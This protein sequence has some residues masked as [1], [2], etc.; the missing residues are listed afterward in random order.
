MENTRIIPKNLWRVGDIVGYSSQNPQFRA[1][2][3]Q[4]D[5]TTL[6]WRSRYGTG[7]GNGLF[8]VPA[9]AGTEKVTNGGFDSATTGWA[10]ANGTLASIAGGYAGNCLEITAGSGGYQAASQDIGAAVTGKLYRLSVRVKSGTSGNED[11]NLQ[12]DGSILISGTSSADWTEYI[13]YR[14]YAGGD[15]NIA[16]VK[17]TA[18]AGTMLFDSISIQEITSQN[19]ITFDEGST[20]YH[21]ELTAGSYNGTTLATEVKTRLDAL[22]GTYTCAYSETTGKFTIARAA[23]NFTLHWNTATPT[24]AGLL[25]FSTAADDTGA[26]TYT[27][28]YARFNTYEYLDLDNGSALEYDFISL[29]NHNLSSAAVITLYG[30]DDSAFTTNLVSDVIAYNATNISAFLA[31]ARTKR[32]VRV[33]VVD[34]AN[35][36][37]Y[38]S[39]ATIVLGKYRDL[40]CIFIQGYGDGYGNESAMEATP[41]GNRFLTSGGPS[42]KEWDLTWTHLTGTTKAY[43]DEAILECLGSVYALAV[44]FDYTA[45]NDYTHWAYLAEFGQPVN[46]GIGDTG[47]ATWT[48]GAKLREHV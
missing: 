15:V 2:C 29:R 34:P 6:A 41:S 26:A 4:D 22:G 44:C 42:L 33:K 30:A 13:L 28:D 45:P 9:Y 31:A 8:V 36:A 35:A 43:V 39:I 14:I 40:G 38:N 23:G 7:T 37:G 5:D 12:W 24:A 3:A 1:V 21:A 46:T 18:T 10:A 19:I 17:N 25:G 11:F 16:V 20:V 32:Y 47:T 27:S 48:W